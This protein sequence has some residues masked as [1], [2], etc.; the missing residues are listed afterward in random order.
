MSEK[1]SQ[2]RLNEYRANRKAEESDER[3]KYLSNLLKGKT[4]AL[5]ILEEKASKA[6]SQMFKQEEEFRKRDIER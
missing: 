4:E 1:L 2:I 6:E 5:T 3:V